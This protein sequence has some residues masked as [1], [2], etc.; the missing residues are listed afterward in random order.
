MRNEGEGGGWRNDEDES[1]IE[2]LDYQTSEKGSTK[3]RCLIVYYAST[4]YTTPVQ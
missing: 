2:T 3:H 1:A 4:L